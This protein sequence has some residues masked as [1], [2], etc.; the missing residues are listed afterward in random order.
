MPIDGSIIRKEWFE[1]EWHYSIIDI[2]AVLLDA[3]KK[4]AQNYY[5]V[6][7][8]RL[9]KEG[10]ETLTNCKRLKLVA[11]DGKRRLTDVVTTEA[12]LRLIQSI[13]SPKAEPLKMWLAQVGAQRLE[14]TEDP[15]LGLFRSLERTVDDYR[16]VG[17]PDSWI[18]LRVEGIVTRKR[19][20][21]ALKNAVMDEL[22]GMYAQTTDRLYK[23]LWER[24]TA[25]LRAELEITPKQNPRDHFGKYAL[26]YTRMAEELSTDRLNN[27]ET[28]TLRTA[29]DI[30]WEAAKLFHKQA[31]EL[32]QAVGY[33]LVTEKPL[34][35]KKTKSAR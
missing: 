27:A 17:K 33:D 18:A 9:I 24:T 2:I 3:D 1:N 7:K 31:R 6:L 26:M 25:Q 21:E 10:N 13:P 12:A 15:E 20:V 8:G 19:F 5:H 16:R 28:V 29:M 11:E 4:A 30:V 32:A 23:G 35:P 22:P 14:E 34:L